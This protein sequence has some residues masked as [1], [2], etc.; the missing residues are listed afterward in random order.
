MV[1]CVDREV[2]VG[3]RLYSHRAKVIEAALVASRA[4]DEGHTA[5][6]V[7][8]VRST[9]GDLTDHTARQG[10]GVAN[11]VCLHQCAEASRESAAR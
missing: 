7:N 8:A 10:N 9:E 3:D 2:D 1:Q 6:G 11:H 4:K 5:S